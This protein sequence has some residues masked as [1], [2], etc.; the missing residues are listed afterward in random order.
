MQIS[1]LRSTLEEQRQSAANELAAV[2]AALNNKCQD[3]E[4][5]LTI[6]TSRADE[7]SARVLSHLLMHFSL[8]SSI[9]CQKFVI[10]IRL[11][12]FISIQA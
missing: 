9:A 3:L 8:N 12:S 6:A 11:H 4:H 1:G 2:K 10:Q 7:S 5:R